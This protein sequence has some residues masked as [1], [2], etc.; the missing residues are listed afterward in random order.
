MLWNFE[1]GF[2]KR[3]ITQGVN[4]FKG[5]GADVKCFKSGDSLPLQHEY[6]FVVNTTVSRNEKKK[7][8]EDE[9]RC[10]CLCVWERENKLLFSNQVVKRKSYG[11]SVEKRTFLYTFETLIALFTQ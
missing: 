8:I 2:E 1:F 3:Q 6:S 7:N 10:V 11:L 9:I 5:L 4:G